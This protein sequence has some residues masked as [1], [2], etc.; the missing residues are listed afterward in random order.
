MLE[1]KEG[2]KVGWKGKLRGRFR[3]VDERIT[4]VNIIEPRSLF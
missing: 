2:H 3:I 4:L 1:E